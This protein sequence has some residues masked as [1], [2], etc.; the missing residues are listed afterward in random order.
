MGDDED[1]RHI[2][3]SYVTMDVTT[4]DIVSHILGHVVGE[5][6]YVDSPLSFIIIIFC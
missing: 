1:A 5:Y 4:A 3:A 2:L 6:D